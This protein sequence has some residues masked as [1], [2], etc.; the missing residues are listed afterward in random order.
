MNLALASE[1]GVGLWCWFSCHPR[2]HTAPTWQAAVPSCATSSDLQ[3]QLVKV[4]W[5]ARGAAD[6][7]ACSQEKARGAKTPPAS[8]LNTAAPWW[9]T[10]SSACREKPLGDSS[11]SQKVAP[12]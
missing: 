3:T 6:C 10:G 4:R 2:A 12:S 7:L 1:K 9:D 11:P 5:Q 8:Q